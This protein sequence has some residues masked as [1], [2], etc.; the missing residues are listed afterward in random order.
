MIPVREAV[1]I[2]S[3][4]FLGLAVPVFLLLLRVP[5][6]YGR[7]ARP[8]WG[9]TLHPTPG[10]FV[11]EAP[12]ALV[13]AGWFAWERGWE[14]APGIAYLCL[15]EFHYLYRAFWYP[16]TLRGGSRRIPVSVV[17]MGFVFNVIN[18]SLQ[19]AS[20]YAVVST[21]PQAWFLDGRFLAGTA[22]F[23]AG[24][25]LNRGSDAALRRLRS[26]GAGYRIPTGGAFQYISCPNYLGEI[27]EWCGWALATWTL[28]GL[29]FAAWTTANLVPRALAH[30]RW[31]RERFPDYPRD[32]KALIPGIL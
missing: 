16:W 1:D 25:A 8:G 24:L 23:V 10:W 7:H 9:P 27:I 5:A 15:W 32:R 19:G 13:M 30:H 22:L 21:H 14:A 6:P 28:A 26:D 31:Y 11:M 12:A 29:A 18:A 4:V 2:A 3:R 20:L 17:V